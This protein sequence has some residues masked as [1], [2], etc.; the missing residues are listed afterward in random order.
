MRFFE[1]RL[2]RA[3]GFSNLRTILWLE[4]E[5]D[6]G[7]YR[8]GDLLYFY[9][10]SYCVLPVLSVYFLF[11]TLNCHYLWSHSASFL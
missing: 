11:W 6:A 2:I 5:T 3:M 8:E 4:S 1:K 9:C 10:V 7:G